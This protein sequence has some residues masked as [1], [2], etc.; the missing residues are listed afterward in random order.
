MATEMIR[1]EKNSVNKVSVLMPA[2][3]AGLLM[4]TTTASPLTIGGLYKILP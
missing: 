4:K 2:F 1:S 3:N